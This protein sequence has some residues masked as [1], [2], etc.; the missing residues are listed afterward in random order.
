MVNEAKSI[1]DLSKNIT[2]KNKAIQNI[3][4]FFKMVITWFRFA[5]MKIQP[6]QPG[7]ISPYDNMEVSGQL[8]PRKIA[9]PEGFVLGLGLILELGGNFPRGQFSWNQ[10]V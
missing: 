4:R 1:Y 3:F 5:R 8:P 10:H 9:P 7:Q 6:V 2:T